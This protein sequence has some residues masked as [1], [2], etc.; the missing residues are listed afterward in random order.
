MNEEY[1]QCPRCNYATLIKGNMKRHL[2]KTKECDNINLIE[3]TDIVKLNTLS[4]KIPKTNIKTTKIEK[5]ITK[6]VEEIIVDE[7]IL[8]LVEKNRK[9]FEKININIDEYKYKIALRNNKKQLTG[10]TIVDEKNFIE[11]NKYSWYESLLY[12][13][14]NCE[15]L[16]MQLHQYILPNTPEG[17]IIDHI[18]GNKLDNRSAN[19]RFATYQQN[20]QNRESLKGSS[21]QY[22]G[23][24]RCKKSEKWK[25]QSHYNNKNI[26]LGTFDNEID[27]ALTYD[28]FVLL[29]YGEKAKT[30]NLI[31]FNEVKHLDLE[32]FL[33]KKI[34]DLPKFIR[35]KLNSY[36]VLIIYKN[37]RY[38]KTLPTLELAKEKLI[39]F[40][41]IINQI[42]LNALEIHNKRE[43]LRNENNIAIIPIKNSN[44]EIIE[45]LLVSD[46][47]WYD[48]M[49]YKWSRSGNYYHTKINDQ[50]IRIHRY[51]MKVTDPKIKVD[52]INH[53]GKNNT[54]ENLRLSNSQ[55]NNHN[56]SKKQNT[57]SKYI[58][59]SLCKKDK[60]YVSS[61]RFNSKRH[62]LGSFK[63][64]IDAA[65]AY[66]NKAT[67]FYGTYANL[68]IIEN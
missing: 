67:E 65:I 45:N 21:S 7:K 47:C 16:N 64:E 43:I 25:C 11:A 15:T 66:N 60:T 58:G 6:I 55:L 30:N 34:R 19:L 14:S 49:L 18:N 35:K 59:V 8:Q 31:T 2:N 12:A 54:L 3:L 32:T 37:T 50:L 26:G 44:D 57:S 36:E 68:N 62:Y 56:K 5:V 13:R 23:V 1:Y 4:I 41:N 33:E 48:L 24:T 61:I 42:K 53:D 22:L 17:M 28:K 27:A 51:I 52:H 63:N 38:N 20:G 9:D 46:S 10:Y 39:E 40:Q 29:H